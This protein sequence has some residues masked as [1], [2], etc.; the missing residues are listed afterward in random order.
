MLCKF[1]RKRKVPGSNPTAGKDIHFVILVCAHKSI[2][3]G[4]E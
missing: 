2:V 1:V 4:I 3:Y